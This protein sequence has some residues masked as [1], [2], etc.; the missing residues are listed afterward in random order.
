MGSSRFICVHAAIL[1]L[2]SSPVA[3][4]RRLRVRSL[5][6]AERYGVRACGSQAPFLRSSESVPSPVAARRLR[7]RS[8]RRAERCGVRAV[9]LHNSTCALLSYAIPLKCASAHSPTRHP[10]RS[11][12]RAC[13]FALASLCVS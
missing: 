13:R 9:A 2:I 5:R 6:R 12:R 3:P 1:P 7:V 4:A 10:L 11:L 8:L